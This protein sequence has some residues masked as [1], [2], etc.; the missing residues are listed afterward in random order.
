M[1]KGNDSRLPQSWQ[2]VAELPYTGSLAAVHEQVKALPQADVNFFDELEDNTIRFVLHGH[3]FR[4]EQVERQLYFW[5]DDGR[6]STEVL[7]EPLC[8]LIST[9]GIKRESPS[10]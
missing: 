10:S 9:L 5:V 3:C 2:I 1:A 6:C 4:L 7:M 8:H